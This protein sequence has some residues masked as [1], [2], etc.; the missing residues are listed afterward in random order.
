M[1]RRVFPTGL[2][3]DA[4]RGV[5]GAVKEVVPIDAQLHLLA[6]QRE[7]VL[8][9]AALIEHHVDRTAEDDADD[10]PDAAATS[11]GTKGGRKP[12]AGRRRS[13]SRR[14]TRV[15]LD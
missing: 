7:L 14:P 12:A 3:E 11:D 4:L 8:A 2:V 9:V 15:S 13:A 1:T 6:A 10:E 5:A